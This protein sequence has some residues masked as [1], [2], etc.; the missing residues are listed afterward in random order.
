MKI[1]IETT[2]DAALDEVW[3][4]W[5]EPRRIVQWNF[6]S[7]DWHCP[8]AEIDLSE[9]G[10]FNYR[11][12]AR[13]GSMGFD[14]EGVFTAIEPHREIRYTLGDQREV[15]IGFSESQ[16][17]VRVL[18]TFETEDELGTEQQRQGWQSILQN[19][20]RYVETGGSGA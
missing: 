18:E 6:A 5:I 3:N 11:M 12:E 10:R 14:F 1:T 4:A 8:R 20:K 19:F 16:G 13:D 2:V 9:G 17:G 7:D 15:T